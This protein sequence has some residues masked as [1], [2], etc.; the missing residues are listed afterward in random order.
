MSSGAAHRLDPLGIVR[1]APREHAHLL[2]LDQHVVA[3]PHDVLHHEALAA[4]LVDPRFDGDLVAVGRRAQEARRHVDQRR[5]DDAGR[6]LQLGPWR[7]AG[8]DERMPRGRIDP[9]EEIRIED[10][11]RGIAVAE[12]DGEARRVAAA[13]WRARPRGGRAAA[14]AR[15]LRPADRLRLHRPRRRAVATS[16]RSSALPPSSASAASRARGSPR[17]RSAATA[18]R[19]RGEVIEDVQQV[20]PCRARWSRRSP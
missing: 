10:D 3:A 13:S 17:A 15:R 8:G 14:G 4:P 7:N 16:A 12:L 20:A 9:A 19:R 18:R 1:M 5:A 11:L 6:G 2:P